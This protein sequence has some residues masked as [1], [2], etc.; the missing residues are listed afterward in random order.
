[1]GIFLGILMV[2]VVVGAAGSV[3]WTAVDLHRLHRTNRVLSEGSYGNGMVAFG[4]GG[5]NFL[6][7]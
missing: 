7:S 1:M 3:L 4:I 6:H 2:C 5:S